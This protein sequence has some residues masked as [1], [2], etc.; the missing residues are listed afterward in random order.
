MRLLKPK[1]YKKEPIS[2]NGFKGFLFE[3]N[4]QVFEETAFVGKENFIISVS[5]SSPLNIEG[6]NK[7]LLDILQSLEWQ[8]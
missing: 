4:T 6:L 3:K 2:E 7:E 8:K 5:L 1:E